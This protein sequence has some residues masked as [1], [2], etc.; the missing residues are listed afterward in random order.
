MMAKDRLHQMPLHGRAVRFRLSCPSCA[1][2][3]DPEAA[4]V[5]RSTSTT[6]S[7]AT[8]TL[9]KN[10]TARKAKFVHLF[11]RPPSPTGLTLSSHAGHPLHCDP[12]R[13]ARR[14]SP[15]GSGDLQPLRALW[16]YQDGLSARAQARDH[17]ARVLRLEGASQNDP[18][19]RCGR[20]DLVRNSQATVKAFDQLNGTPLGGGIAELRFEWDKPNPP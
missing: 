11:S 20:A 7:L 17:D 3:D 5:R 8:P 9:H 1:S 19:L 4:V 18:W 13:S 10:A 6:R 12:Q 2:A 14:L 15:L 16:R